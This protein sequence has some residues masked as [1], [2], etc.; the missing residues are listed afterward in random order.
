VA[1]HVLSAVMVHY[2]LSSTLTFP[3]W[4]LSGTVR[5]FGPNSLWT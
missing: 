2:M 3:K 5:L 4:I 1:L